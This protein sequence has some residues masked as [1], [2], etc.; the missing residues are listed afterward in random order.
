M[1]EKCFWVA[2][3]ALCHYPESASPLLLDLCM[4]SILKNSCSWLTLPNPHTWY[5]EVYNWKPCFDFFDED[6]VA[7]L[8]IPFGTLR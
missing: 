3:A 7:S 4:V 6:G 8:N 2:A 1:V 5:S